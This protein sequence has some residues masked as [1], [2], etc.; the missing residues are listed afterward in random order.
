[1]ARVPIT[2]MGCRCER[3]LYEWIPR[4][5]NVEPEA[6]PK[7][8]SPYWNRPKRHGADPMTSYEHF[9]GAVERVLRGSPAP[10]TWTEI[11][12]MASLPQKFPN[13]QWVRQLEAEIG[14]RRSK[15]AHGII[16]WTVG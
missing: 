7:C 5:L 11:R 10:V 15:D 16:K 13:N 6:C 2:V 4:D 14:L 1:M 8:K 12:T 9:R 3:C